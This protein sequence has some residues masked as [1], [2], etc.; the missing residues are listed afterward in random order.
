MTLSTPKQVEKP[1]KELWCLDETPDIPGETYD[2]SNAI[3]D[4]IIFPGNK[5]L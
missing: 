4:P 1:L 5:R 3:A 2:E